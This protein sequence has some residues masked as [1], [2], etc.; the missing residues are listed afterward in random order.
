MNKI[1]VLILTTIAAS[2]SSSI[3]ATT[4]KVW[5]TPQPVRIE[6]IQGLNGVSR[7][8]GEAR[9]RVR[10]GKVHAISLAVSGKDD[11]W[12][13][14]TI[15]VVRNIDGKKHYSTLASVAAASGMSNSISFAFT[16]PFK[17]KVFGANNYAEIV[18]N[19]G[20]GFDCVISHTVLY[21]SKW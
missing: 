6:A 16:N 17:V 12:C 10:T 7:G 15:R 19:R 4:K 8:G 2:W 1:A 13:S 14:A 18:V 11:N 5:T 3:G 20:G 21:E 9:F